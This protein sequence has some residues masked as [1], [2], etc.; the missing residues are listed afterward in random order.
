MKWITEETVTVTRTVTE[1]HGPMKI[2]MDYIIPGLAA[3]MVLFVFYEVISGR[4][5]RRL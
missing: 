4:F 3:V 1:Y 2:L 5:P